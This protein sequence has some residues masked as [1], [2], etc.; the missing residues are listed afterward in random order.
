M[1]R[2]LFVICAL[3]VFPA[4][5][6]AGIAN[7]ADTVFTHNDTPKRKN[8]SSLYG[9]ENCN[10]YPYE[11]K[12]CKNGLIPKLPC[13][14]DSGRYKECG[15]PGSLVKIDE[16]ADLL[17]VDPFYLGFTGNEECSKFSD[18]EAIGY[19]RMAD[20]CEKDKVLHCP[21]DERFAYCL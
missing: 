17:N 3:F 13:P 7:I 21:F 5:V 18:C 14:S 6:Q 11:A 10:A 8:N 19:G 20:S 2:F 9:L 1:F 16:F 4:Y 15:C 12:D